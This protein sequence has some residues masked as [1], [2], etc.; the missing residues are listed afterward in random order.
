MNE[1]APQINGNVSA[2][3]I[4]SRSAANAVP[5]FEDQYLLPAMCE[6]AR[7]YSTS[8]SCSYD[9]CVQG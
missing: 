1:T 5:R 6:V 2:L 3:C 7:C 9:D 8:P 4:G